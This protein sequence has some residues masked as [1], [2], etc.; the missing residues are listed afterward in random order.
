MQ[1]TQTQP[2]CVHSFLPFFPPSYLCHHLSIR[3]S[4]HTFHHSVSQSSSSIPS[5]LSSAL[6]ITP[7]IITI[8]HPFYQH[9]TP[10]CLQMTHPHRSLLASSLVVINYRHLLI[11]SQSIASVR[12]SI[13]S[14]HPSIT[15]SHQS[16]PCNIMCTCMC[17]MYLT[18]YLSHIS[19]HATSTHVISHNMVAA[20]MQVMAYHISIISNI[21]TTTSIYHQSLLSLSP[22]LSGAA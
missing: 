16:S 12:S 3:L 20:D 15:I 6:S 7:T 1:Q 18:S 5:S 4:R 21:S 8:S 10:G 19:H 11:P 14:M 13:A 2:S 9:I 22:T 17:G